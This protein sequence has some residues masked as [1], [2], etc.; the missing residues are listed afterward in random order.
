MKP[1][2]TDSTSFRNLPIQQ[3]PI[4]SWN[5]VSPHPLH[6]LM[7]SYFRAFRLQWLE[8]NPAL[9]G[10]RWISDHPCSLWS[11]TLC[12][13]GHNRRRRKEQFFRLPPGAL[14]AV[15][16]QWDVLLVSQPPLDLL[17]TKETNAVLAISRPLSAPSPLNLLV[18]S[19]ESDP[20]RTHL[21]WLK[22]Q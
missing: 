1:S 17:H 13:R 11:S 22:K 3:D 18:L 12:L 5:Q 20:V 7:F 9:Q 15:E 16:T 14:A 2:F 6:E 10:A 4:R 21:A 8:M 19:P